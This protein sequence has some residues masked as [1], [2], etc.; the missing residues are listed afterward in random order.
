[1]ADRRQVYLMSLMLLVADAV[2]ECRLTGL[3]EAQSLP[4]EN[5]TVLVTRV[6]SE[7][8]RGVTQA[9]GRFALSYE[10]FPA[11]LHAATVSV[12]AMGHVTDER[13]FF[14][15]SDF[16][17]GVNEHHVDLEREPTGQPQDSSSLGLTIFIIPYTLYG[18]GADTIAEGF[19]QD[20]PGIVHH[21]ILAY[22]SQLDIST[23]QVDISVEIVDNKTIGNPVT[24]AQGE[25][26]RRL[27]HQ[28]KALAV[29]AGDGEIVPGNNGED[30]IDLTSIFRTI[31]AY[32]DLGVIMQPINDQLPARRASPS[33]IANQMHD[34]WGK[35]AVLSYVLQRLA[36]HQGEWQS[37]EL[38][39]LADL[40]I[41]V[42]NTMAND[43]QLLQPLQDLLAYVEGGIEP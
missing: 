18:Q 19:N 21:L 25:R 1:M 10:K 7:I 30:Q 34:L 41:E 24:A 12:N 29:I 28:L 9:D 20:L 16:C 6:D 17:L 42:R 14:E 27:G 2:A 13:Q 33:R 4:L 15:G 11:R 26:I 5:A 43:D 31:P 8:G 22:K 35:Q 36:T 38:K 37:D 3:I 40:L 39:S 23:A 32:R